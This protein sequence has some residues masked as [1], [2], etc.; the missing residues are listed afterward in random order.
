MREKKSVESKVFLVSIIIMSLVFSVLMFNMVIAAPYGA[1]VSLNNTTSA[2]PDVAQQHEA[3]AGN[4]TEL[5]I[6]GFTT[7]RSWQG[8]YGNVTGV[9]QLADSADFVMYNWTETNPRG[10]IYAARNQ[11]I[12]WRYVQCFNYTATGE[13]GDDLARAGQTS[14]VGMN[15]TQLDEMYN[16]SLDDVDGVNNTFVYGPSG[17]TAGGH[18]LFYT[19]NLKFD[20]DECTSMKVY[21]STGVGDFQEVLM[22]EPNGRTIIFNA[23]LKRDAD[24]FNAM[25]HD[26]EMLV[27]EDAHTTD[28]VPT[29]YYFYMELG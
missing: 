1:Q 2:V 20:A 21:N 13:Y 27:L 26:F 12:D 28:I 17:I 8:Y 5:T 18:Q 11:T 7:T 16:I 10:E 24:G 4:V 6:Y 15:Y 29:T 9:V 22:Y 25:T 3:Y 23:I 14:L 19:N